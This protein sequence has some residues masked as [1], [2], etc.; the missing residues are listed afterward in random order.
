MED[1]GALYER[2]AI[3]R[4]VQ[5]TPNPQKGVANLINV[6]AQGKPA[7]VWA[8]A[9]SFAYNSERASS[10][11]WMVIPLLV[12]GYEMDK[13]E[14][15]IADR[16]CVPLTATTDELR[17]ARA[18]IA[19]TKH[20]IMTVGNPDLNKLPSA[21]R[22]GIR[23]CIKIFVDKPPV[24]PKTSFGFDAYKKWAELLTN[25]KGKQSWAKMFAPGALMYAG[26]TSTYKYI[27]LWYTGGRGAR[28]E[29]GFARRAQPR[30]MSVSRSRN[31]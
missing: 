27:E 5:Q 13:D 8:D 15:L 19:K 10:D 4:N 21:I 18:R 25:T 2:L 11:F 30:W 20:R 16:S 3:P 17:A 24:G 9:S 23:S 14:V 29:Y 7:V 22:E 26:L 12:Y 31:A 1:P 28:G 6:L